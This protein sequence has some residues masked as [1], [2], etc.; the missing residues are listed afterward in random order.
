[1]SDADTAGQS[2]AAFAANLAAIADTSAFQA[3]RLLVREEIVRQRFRSRLY[4]SYSKLFDSPAKF[5]GGSLLTAIVSL[6]LG[7]RYGVPVLALAGLTLLCFVGGAI[8]TIHNDLRAA[9][10]DHVAERL[11]AVLKETER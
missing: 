11:E 9:R 4:S 8:L 2:L 5:G 3:A 6:I 10:T 7:G 1:M